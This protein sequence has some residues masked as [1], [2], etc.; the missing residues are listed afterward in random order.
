MCSRG[1]DPG[2]ERFGE[3]STVTQPE[4]LGAKPQAQHLQEAVA[5]PPWWWW[6]GHTG[7]PCSEGGRLVRAGGA[8]PAGARSCFTHGLCS[9]PGIMEIDQ[10]VCLGMGDPF[11]VGHRSTKRGLARGGAIG[12][13]RSQG[14]AAPGTCDCE[15]DPGYSRTSFLGRRP[16]PH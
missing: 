15:R 10:G 13:G 3:G 2:T 1:R 11:R 7:A 14:E 12:G 16:G 4:A 5:W 6:A 9:A 8:M